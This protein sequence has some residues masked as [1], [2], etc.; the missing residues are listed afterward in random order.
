VW[1]SSA[2]CTCHPGG[3]AKTRR[4]G[5]PLRRHGGI[6][7]SGGRS[8]R[9]GPLRARACADTSHVVQNTPKLPRMQAHSSCVALKGKGGRQK[10]VSRGVVGSAV[11]AS[12]SATFRTCMAYRN[13]YS[14]QE[15]P[16]LLLPNARRSPATS[17]RARQETSLFAI[18]LES[19]QRKYGERWAPTSSESSGGGRLANHSSMASAAGFT[20]SERASTRTS[21]VFS[22]ASM[23]VRWCF[24]TDSRKRVRKRQPLSWKSPESVN[25]KWRRADE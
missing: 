21:T 9:R 5:A 19:C 11:S 20:K 14:W 23:T 25:A 22:F 7:P 1:G 15:G 4:R 2:R 24:C 12:R 16:C 10:R 3:P 6:P 8:C 17:T 13:R 18:G